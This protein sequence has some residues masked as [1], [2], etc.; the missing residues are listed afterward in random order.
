[1]DSWFRVLLLV[2]C[3]WTAPEGALCHCDR[4]VQRGRGLETRHE[5]TNR[6]TGVQILVET[7]ALH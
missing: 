2:R 5:E 1:M 3:C 4:H 6:P 7:L